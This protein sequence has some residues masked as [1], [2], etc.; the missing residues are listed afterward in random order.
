MKLITKI[1]SVSAALVIAAAAH[2]QTTAAAK[3]TED[4]GLIGK[5]YVSATM[6]YSDVHSSS[7]GLFDS[8]LTFNMPVLSNVDVGASYDYSWLEGHRKINQ[9]VPSVYA[10]G[11]LTE[12]ALKPF[13]TVELGYAWDRNPGFQ[14]DD[15]LVYATAAGVQWSINQSC[16]LTVAAGRA[17]DFK[18][19]D[20]SAYS[21]TIGFNVAVTKSVDLLVQ[22]TW[23]EH[24]TGGA[25]LGVAYRF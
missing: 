24:S 17:A 25:G 20:N 8:T 21:G 13:A 22:G 11:Y 19:G 2:A 15:R 23:G 18:A 4:S 1:A 12:G 14:R 16:A 6:S 3:A 5:R 9:Q 7:W 10:T